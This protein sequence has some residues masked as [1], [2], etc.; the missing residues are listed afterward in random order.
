MQ[1]QRCHQLL[2]LLPS[3]SSLLL[4]MHDDMVLLLLLS[5]TDGVKVSA[6]AANTKSHQLLLHQLI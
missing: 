2:L 4:Q 1:R 5:M 6:A 3:H